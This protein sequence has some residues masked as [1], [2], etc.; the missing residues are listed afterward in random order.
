[1]GSKQNKAQIEQLK[2]DLREAKKQGFV[3]GYRPH[4]YRFLK[5]IVVLVILGILAAWMFQRFG[6][7]FIEKSFKLL[8]TNCWYSAKAN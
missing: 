2:R 4:R 7:N 5:L 3:P 8:S 6:R 1:M